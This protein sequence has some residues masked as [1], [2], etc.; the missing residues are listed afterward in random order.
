MRVLIGGAGGNLGRCAAPALQRAGHEVR[1]FD[2][3]PVVHAAALH[4]IHSATG[5]TTIS[6]R[7]TSTA[8]SVS[9][10]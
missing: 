7:P 4:G 3:R 1:L 2:F 8:P 6:G 5:R 9:T 10:T